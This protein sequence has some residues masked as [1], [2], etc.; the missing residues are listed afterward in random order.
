MNLRT[1]LPLAAAA[2]AG[3]AASAQVFCRP[4]TW[5]NPTGASTA[6]Y[7]CVAAAYCATPLGQT[8]NIR[9]GAYNERVTFNKSAQITSTNGPAVIGLNPA[10]A[11]SLKV[12]TFNTHLFGS[13]PLP[14][15][16]DQD[17]AIAIGNYL[18]QQRQNGLDI[19]G[20]QEVWATDRW[21][22]IRTRA[23]FPGFGYGGRIDG[24]GTQN[25]GLAILSAHPISG[26][27]Q[28]SYNDERG[29]DASA[30]KGFL[31]Q[32]ITKGNFEIGVFITHT[33]SGSGTNDANTRA[34]QFAQ[35]ASTIQ[36]YKNLRPSNP[37]IVMGDFNAKDI[38]VEYTAIMS[39]QFGGVSGVAD[40]ALN[41]ACLGDGTQ[42]TTCNDNVVRQ[43]FGGSGNDRI[44]YIMYGNSLDGTVRIIPKVYDV[45][46]P[47]SPTAISGTGWDPEAFLDFQLTSNLLSDHEAIYAEFEVTRP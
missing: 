13:F 15:W 29:N 2:L 47:T 38:S 39:N 10:D 33:Q 7:S 37:V 31:V 30:T 45:R 18:S 11:V 40:L 1:L 34:S 41:L 8:L 12:V 9:N 20:L 3:Q 32:T 23:G 19:A 6:P 42:C 44:D 28:V 24:A 5:F 21:D 14:V 46:R 22:D 16:Q 4:I 17:R 26:G 35:L 36:V 27:T 25:S 43:A